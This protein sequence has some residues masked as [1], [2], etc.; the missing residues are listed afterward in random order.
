[1]PQRN[2][3]KTLQILAAFFGVLVLS[4]SVPAAI[5]IDYHGGQN[6]FQKTFYGAFLPKYERLR[7]CQK[8]KVVVLGTS[9]VAFGIDSLLLEE[10]LAHANLDYDVVGYGLYGALGTRLMM[11]TALPFLQKGDIAIL[12]PE[13]FPQTLSNYFSVS[14]TYRAIEKDTRI[15][16]SLSSDE[17]TKMILGVPSYLSERHQHKEPIESTGVYAASSFDGRG[18]MT[19]ERLANIMPY[20]FDLNT[21]LSLDIKMFDPSFVSYVNDYAHVLKGRDASIYFRFCPLDVLGLEEGYRS[22]IDAFAD[23]IDRLLDFPLLGNPRESIMKENWFYDSSFHLNSAG[24]QDNTLRLASQIKLE[25]GSLVPNKHASPEMPELP[26]REEQEIYGDDVDEDCFL[27]D[28]DGDGLSLIGVGEEYKKRQ[29]LIL[30]THHQG[31]YVR[32]LSQDLFAGCLS[33]SKVTIQENISLL[34][35]GLFSSSPDLEEI[36][37]AHRDPSKLQVGWNLLL[38]ANKA[39][40]YVPQSSL[41]SYQSDYFWAHYAGR[42][43][44]E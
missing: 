39:K 23:E 14:E 22:K 20:Y 5:A 32:A 24:A 18:D 30:P 8:K 35:D 40:I 43:V 2:R 44:G 16:N 38:G 1:M 7:S 33:L 31:K 4:S 27:Y 28:P 36:H 41:S 17:Q 13:L 42:M 21:P 11:E 6:V 19:F 25:L 12:S 34:Y 29:S 3:R 10:E 9:S 15:L 26:K 37:L